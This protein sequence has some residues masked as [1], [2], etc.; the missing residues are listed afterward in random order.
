MAQ[1]LTCRE[2]GSLFYLED[3]EQAWYI[4][5]G[6]QVPKRCKP[7]REKRKGQ[8]GAYHTRDHGG[9]GAHN[10]PGVHE[11]NVPMNGSA[12]FL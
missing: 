5:K 3:E 11:E 6:L 9:N 1:E 12:D 7:C 10:I 2:C 8:A 4:R